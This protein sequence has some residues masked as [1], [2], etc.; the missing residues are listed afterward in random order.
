MTRFLLKSAIRA[1]GVSPLHAFFE[2]QIHA[3]SE[4]FPITN[5][6]DPQRWLS[7]LLAGKNPSTLAGQELWNIRARQRQILLGFLQQKTNITLNP[8]ALTMVWAR[9]FAAYKRPGI[10]FNDLKRLEKL[11]FP[12]S[13]EHT[14]E[15][16]SQFHL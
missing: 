4:L 1:N 12:R 15:L 8:E 3:Q 10:L 6:I 13:E 14:S 16:Q 11:L 9:R 5:A 7:P 2:K